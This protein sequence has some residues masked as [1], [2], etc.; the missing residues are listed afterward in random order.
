MKLWP[1][2]SRVNWAFLQYRNLDSKVVIHFIFYYSYFRGQ[3]Q[4]PFSKPQLF[5]Q[6]EL[7]AF[8]NRGLRLIHSDINSLL[9]KIG[10]LRD[11]AKRTKAAIIGILESKLDS[12]VLD[13]EI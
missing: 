6:G 3:N 12:T 4:I 2:T 5:K 9:P 13:P 1:H 10:E 7:P 8:S 11:I